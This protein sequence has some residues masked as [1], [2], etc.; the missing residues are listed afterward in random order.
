MALVRFRPF[1]QAVDPFRDLGD[2][3]GEMNRLFDSFFGRPSQQQ[4]GTGMERVWAP[5]V[6]MHETKDDL[7][8]TAELPG[9]SEKDIHLSITGD[10]LTL[11]GE[12]NWNQDM[13]QDNCH[14]VERWFGRFERNL[15]LPMPV[16]ADK[17]KASYRDG[18]LTVTL[19][20]AEEIKPKEIKIDVL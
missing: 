1:G 12:R 5:A 17:V 20:K 9:V 18:V 13:K 16:Q 15:P 19:P 4:S 7:V 10:V 2:I 8:V 14:R 6:D 11:K 3:Q